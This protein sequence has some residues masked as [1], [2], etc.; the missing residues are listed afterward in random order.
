MQGT[1]DSM[2]ARQ[3]KAIILDFGDILT[4]MGSKKSKGLSRY[5]W[6]EDIPDIDIEFYLEI[7]EAR[8]I[9]SK[10]LK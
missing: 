9:P 6:K 2:L 8:L 7:V 3:K 1:V 5:V 4:K 10:Y